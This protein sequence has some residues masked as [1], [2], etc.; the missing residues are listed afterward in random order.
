M[1]NAT[2]DTLSAT[3]G[4]IQT[5]DVSEATIDT[6]SATN[7]SI[8]TLDVS[9]ATIVT[10]DVSAATFNHLD[11]SSASVSD[12]FT[13]RDAF[14]G[15]K[16]PTDPSQNFVFI[17]AIAGQT[18]AHVRGSNL[19]TGTLALGANSTHIDN[20]VLNANGST[21]IGTLTVGDPSGLNVYIYDSYIRG[22]GLAGN[23][24]LGA[25][26]NSFFN[27][28]LNADGTTTFSNPL[29]LSYSML[30]NRHLTTG[31]ILYSPSLPWKSGFQGGPPRYHIPPTDPAFLS[32]LGNDIAD[33]P[34][35]SIVLSLTNIIAKYSIIQVNI[36]FD[37]VSNG[38]DASTFVFS[39]L[40]D[41]F[42]PSNNVTRFI[43]IPPYPSFYTVSFI[44]F[45]GDHYDTS[46]KYLQ[47][48]AQ[49]YLG[50]PNPNPERSINLG[51]YQNS[52]TWELFGIV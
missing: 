36:T 39:L 29:I 22:P 15:D 38:G 30:G 40:A 3:N 47:F 2:I 13:A 28:V 14:I 44:M 16:Y 9:N 23:L 12:R 1:S 19:S 37:A 20:I 4:S 43:T 45:K 8:Q 52:Y 48:S 24:T 21:T 35:A 26:A 18:V 5:L 32:A 11:A 49:L 46:T 33:V 42:Y 7:G 41:N 31:P 27:I 50:G 10:L 51:N 34:P 6:L 17:N 25:N